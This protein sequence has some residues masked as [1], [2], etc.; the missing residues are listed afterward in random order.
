MTEE[1]FSQ[2]VRRWI[3]RQV[4]RWVMLNAKIDA[5]QHTRR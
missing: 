3:S 1:G 2:L 5:I 4:G